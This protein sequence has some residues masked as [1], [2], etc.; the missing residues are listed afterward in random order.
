MRTSRRHVVVAAVTAVGLALSAPAAAYL[1]HKDPPG[2]RVLFV[3]GRIG[4][5][6]AVGTHV[7]F[8]LHGRRGCR[9][10]VWNAKTATTRELA[11]R[12]A[13]QRLART[14]GSSRVE[15]D[16]S[17]ARTPPLLNVWSDRQLIHRWALPARPRTL[18]VEGHLAVFSAKGGAGLYAV[19]LVDGHVGL[20]GPNRAED[21]PKL[22]SAG[23]FYQDDEFKQDR[24]RGIVRLKFV[25]TAGISSIIDRAQLPLV[26]NGRIASLAMDGP[27]VALAV[28]DPTRTCDRVLYWN[29][30]WRP[31]QR[32]SAPD[33]PT[34]I[35]RRRTA[36]RRVAI[37]GFRAAWLRSSGAEQAIVAGSP[38][39]QEWV[40]RRLS[41]G[42]G[43]AAVDAVVGDG[44]VL[45]FAITRHEREL[46]GSS[47]VAVIS[48][49]FRAIDIASRP[50]AVRQLATDRGRVAVL[51]DDGVVEVRGVRGRL[52]HQFA[53]DRVRAMSLSGDSLLALGDTGLDVYSLK[54]AQ[55]VSSWAVPRDLRAIDM[56][57]RIVVFASGRTV[58]GLDLRSGRRAVL[59]RAAGAIVGAQIEAAGVSYAYNV[60]PRGVARFVPIDAVLQALGDS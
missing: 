39:C 42:P 45:A 21:T 60:G 40:I 25:P 11:A 3:H 4:D 7:T 19:S 34:C 35:V 5:Y 47:E 49:R 30:A 38:R 12:C 9:T 46:R 43:G 27:R 20:I 13:R 41:A 24:T 29:V 50:A 48:G 52:L 26:T 37:G 14:L 32:I 33:G 31:V 1:C 54:K 10:F 17:D 57:Y 36:V 16:A 18:A 6:A 28:A 15:I 23:V 59:G 55:R 44:H 2:T 22:T 8:A 58:Y 53:L 56:H 51:W